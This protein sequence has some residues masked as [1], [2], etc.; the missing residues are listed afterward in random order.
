MAL[1]TISQP[2]V[3]SGAIQNRTSALGVG[4]RGRGIWRAIGLDEQPRDDYRC[5][6]GQMDARFDGA[7]VR[8]RA[9]GLHH[10]QR[11]DWGQAR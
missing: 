9:K 5:Q 7:P 4:L 3:K 8:L 10:G 11:L 1:A 2:M 6:M